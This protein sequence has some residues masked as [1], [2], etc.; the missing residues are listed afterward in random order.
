MS[1]KF[2]QRLDEFFKNYQDRGM[3]KWSGFFLSDHR[4]KLHKDKEYRSTI[5]FKLPEMSEIEISKVLFKAFSDNYM[6][7]VQFKTLNEER[8]YAAN[9]NG[10]V[11]GYSDT[12]V[13]NI[14]GTSVK[15][16]EINHVEIMK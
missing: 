14:S 12:D 13:V 15:L 11:E 7:S 16:T 8:D 10:F 2:D 9:I 3:Q 6:V 5:Y 4:V 1:S